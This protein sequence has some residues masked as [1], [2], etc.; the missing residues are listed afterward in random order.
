MNVI[1][2]LATILGGIAA[3]WYFWDKYNSKGPK[4]VGEELTMEYLPEEPYI[5]THPAATKDHAWRCQRIKLKNN[6]KVNFEGCKVKIEK[7]KR[8]DGKDFTNA[9]LPI[10]LTTQHQKLQKRK[11]GVF[12]LAAGEE[13]LIEVACLDEL[14]SESEIRL[15]YET[16]EYPNPVPRRDYIL[17]I[18]AY[19]GALPTIGYFR[20]YVDDSGFLCLKK[21]EDKT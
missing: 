19:G 2:G 9:F 4:E 16:N 5:M 13:K 21:Y 20:L 17:K 15:Q 14:A 7:M 18:I 3:V 8:A 6:T 1:L 12:N 11:G 10:C